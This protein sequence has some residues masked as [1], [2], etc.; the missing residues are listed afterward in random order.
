M[1]LAIAALIFAAKTGQWP[2]RWGAV[3]MFTGAVATQLVQANLGIEPPIWAACL[4]DTV[5]MLALLVL[6]IRSGRFWAGVAACAQSLVVVFTAVKYFE[7]PLSGPAYLIAL[8][9]SGWIA[10]FA[11]LIGAMAVRW[12]PKSEWDEG[13]AAIA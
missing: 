4:V 1:L 8:H 6:T 12:G 9:L 2:E 13:H 3:I 10:I 7:F 11:L 5:Q